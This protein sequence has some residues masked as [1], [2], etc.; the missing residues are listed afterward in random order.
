VR[1][2]NGKPDRYVVHQAGVPFPEREELGDNDE[3]K[4]EP[5]PDDKPRDPWQSTRFV[6]LTNPETANL[7]TFTTSSWGGRGA[8]IDLSDA[9]VRY[10]HARPGA[11][12]VV[13]LQSAP[14][15]TKFGKKWKP[16]FQI[17]DWVGG[18][19]AAQPPPKPGTKLIEGTAS[20]REFDDS[21]PFN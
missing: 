18:D 15:T 20:N 10:R 17:V 2:A 13:V 21:I 8:V 5:G 6:H 1:W 11:C 14:M 7:Y 9:I 12:P 16:V 19:G 3:T 4:W